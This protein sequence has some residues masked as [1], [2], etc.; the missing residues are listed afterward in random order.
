MAM[1]T[2]DLTRILAGINSYIYENGVGIVV[3][4]W[5]DGYGLCMVTASFVPNAGLPLQAMMEEINGDQGI[6]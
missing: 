5:N 4:I 2:G 1:N 6:Q 3:G